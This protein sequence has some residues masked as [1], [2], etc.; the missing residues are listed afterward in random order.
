[1]TEFVGAEKPSL[2]ELVI[3]HYGVKGMKWGEH[4]AK[5]TGHDIKEAR[6]SVHN[7]FSEIRNQKR[8]N[9]FDRKAGRDTSKGE[10]KVA[11]MT[12]KLLKD[13]DRITASRLTRGEKAAAII[14]LTPAGAAGFIGGAA[15]G[16]QLVKKEVRDAHL[17]G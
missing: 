6:R 9:K 16:R 8:A 13:P 15:L 4:K 7:Q 5:P 14:L 11:K 12:S 17:K 3:S 2:S 10:A 1:M